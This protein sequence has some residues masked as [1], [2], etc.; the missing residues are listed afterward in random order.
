M[1]KKKTHLCNRKY[2]LKRTSKIRNRRAKKK[3]KIIKVS[4]IKR[5]E[6]Q[7]EQTENKFDS[8]FK[9]NS[10]IIIRPNKSFYAEKFLTFLKQSGEYS[11]VNFNF[12]EFLAIFSIQVVPQP[13]DG[14]CFIYCIQH[15]FNFF[16]NQNFSLIDIKTKVKEFVLTNFE[17]LSNFI[18][19]NDYKNKLDYLILTIDNYFHNGQFNNEIVDII[20]QRFNSI[21]GVSLC[22]V[23]VNNENRLSLN[24]FNC[25]PTSTN[26]ENLYFVVKR[27]VIEH[28]EISF[29]HFDSII[30]LQNPITDSNCKFLNNFEVSVKPK[31]SKNITREFETSVKKLTV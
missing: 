19:K 17:D 7:L 3:N 1:S 9:S 22:I 6:I 24:I 21:F 13:K 27:T 31:L 5:D 10:S 20:T 4:A 16:L 11:M 23:N 14:L 15:F 8:N 2:N 18:L 30:P 26:Y 28:D 12:D 29:S 25:D